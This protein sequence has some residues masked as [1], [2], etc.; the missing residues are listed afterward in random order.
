[1]R[2]KLLIVMG[3]VALGIVSLGLSLPTIM[4]GLGFLHGPKN[5]CSEDTRVRISDLT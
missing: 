5:P 3:T 4:H 2:K 1:M